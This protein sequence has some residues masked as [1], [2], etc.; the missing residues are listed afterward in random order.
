MISG[1]RPTTDI[2]RP[3]RLVRFVP[4][5]EVAGLLGD[6]APDNAVLD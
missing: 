5:A 6:Q 1:L 3:A 4:K 2:L